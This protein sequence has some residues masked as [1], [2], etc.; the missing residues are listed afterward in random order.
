MTSMQLLSQT[1][2]GVLAFFFV[3]MLVFELLCC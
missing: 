1:A 2:A 3:A